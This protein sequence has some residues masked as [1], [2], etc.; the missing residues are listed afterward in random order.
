MFALIKSQKK[1]HSGLSEQ[2]E[3]ENIHVYYT[4]VKP[5]LEAT[6]DNTI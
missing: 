3:Q 4:I 1:S 5:Q 6:I 2:K